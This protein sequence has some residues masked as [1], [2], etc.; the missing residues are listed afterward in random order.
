MNDF[1][2]RKQFLDKYY[3]EFK[4]LQKI[5]SDVP[6]DETLS[7]FCCAFPEA[8]PHRN[9]FYQRALKEATE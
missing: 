8:E 1:Q 9:Y 6:L 4:S 2:K 5:T 7:L 3:Q